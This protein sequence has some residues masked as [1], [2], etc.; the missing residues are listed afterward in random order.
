MLF[1]YFLYLRLTISIDFIPIIPLV[2]VFR[3]YVGHFNVFVLLVRKKNGNFSIN[4]FNQFETH[5][6][7]SLRNASARNQ[8]VS[9]VNAWFAD[10]DGLLATSSQRSTQFDILPMQQ[11]PFQ[12]WGIVNRAHDEDT[13]YE[14]KNACSP[15]SV[16]SF[17]AFFSGLKV[18]ISLDVELAIWKQW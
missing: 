15:N 12:E 9:S 10:H 8:S 5:N 13:C 6:N 2:V 7:F 16:Y 3:F 14:S 18:T 1:C 11:Q 4:K 17:I